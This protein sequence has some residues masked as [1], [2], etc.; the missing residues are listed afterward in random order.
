MTT[1]HTLTRLL[2][3]SSALALPLACA[4]ATT[5]A[6]NPISGNVYWTTGDTLWSCDS[7]GENCTQGK[8]MIEPTDTA[9]TADSRMVFATASSVYVCND[10]GQACIEV[11]LPGAMTAAGLSVSPSGEIFVVGT[12]GSLARCS[13]TSCRAVPAKPDTKP[14]DPK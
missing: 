13:E 5:V 9:I 7:A 1:M 12:S 11:K 8:V 2:L 6:I 14:S 10:E 3:L 4:T